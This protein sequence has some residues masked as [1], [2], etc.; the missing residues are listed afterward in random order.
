MTGKV[1]Y[2]DGGNIFV[3]CG[4]TLVPLF[5]VYHNR[6]PYYPIVAGYCSIIHKVMEQTLPHVTLVFDCRFL[7]PAVGYAHCQGYLHLTMS[8]LCYGWGKRTLLITEC[9]KYSLN[10]RNIYQKYLQIISK[11]CNNCTKYGTIYDLNTA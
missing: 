11:S 9:C 3:K 4:D 5:P 7:R 10:L 1:Q 6:E 2:C 8:C